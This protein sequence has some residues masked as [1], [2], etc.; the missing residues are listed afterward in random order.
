MWIVIKMP[1]SIAT[2]LSALFLGL[3]LSHMHADTLRL[4]D[5]CIVMLAVYVLVWSVRGA[6]YVQRTGKTKKNRCRDYGILFLLGL[7]FSFICATFA[8]TFLSLL[9]SSDLV[10]RY[11][12]L[13]YL[14]CGALFVFLVLS[15]DTLEK[16]EWRKVFYGIIAL[17][18]LGIGILVPRMRY[19]PGNV[20]LSELLACHKYRSIESGSDD[21][22]AY[23]KTRHAVCIPRNFCRKFEGALHCN[24]V[25]KSFDG[26]V[27]IRDVEPTSFHA[28]RYAS[29]SGQPLA[30]WIIDINGRSYLWS[31]AKGNG[32]FFE[33][34]KETLEYLG[35][36]YYKDK[37]GFI[38]RNTRVNTRNSYQ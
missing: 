22:F 25:K 33:I 13:T 2:F 23:R 9:I 17:S 19:T 10:A 26:Y 31:L 36:D 32:R 3:F 8:D 20:A 5:V 18:L 4:F 27:R 24:D 29:L 14:L 1:T 16:V 6:L 11:R 38:H 30:H 15:S 28:R 34:D 37:F 12:I 21:M 35:N 7:V